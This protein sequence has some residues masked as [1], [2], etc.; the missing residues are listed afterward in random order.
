[1]I[2]LLLLL[3]PASAVQEEVDA[4]RVRGLLRRL[5]SDRVEDRTRAEDELLAMGEAVIPFLEEERKRAGAEVRRRIGAILEQVTLVPRWVKELVE[6]QNRGQALGRLQQALQKKELDGRRAVAILKASILHER[7]SDN[8]RQSLLSV[9]QRHHLDGVWPALL[10]LAVRE[11]G[12]SGNYAI[13]YLKRLRLPEEAPDAILEAIPEVRVPNHA[14]QLLQLAAGFKPD[15]AKLDAVVRT[16]VEED[17]DTSTQ[18]TLYNAFASGQ[19]RVSLGTLLELWKRPGDVRGTYAN[20]L[21]Q[22][23]LRADPDASV[24]TLKAWVGSEDLKDAL[25]AADYLGRHRVADAIVPMAEALY[26][27]LS[28]PRAGTVMRWSGIQAVGNTAESQQ[29]VGRIAHV[30]RSME[31]GKRI[32][33]W[34]EG[35]EGAPSRPAVFAVIGEL[36][37]TEHA[38]TVAR[39]LEDPDTAVR[40]E[41]VRVLGKIGGVAEVGALRARIG[42]ESRAVRREALAAVCRILGWEATPTV[43]EQLRSKDP[44]LRAAALGELPAM[45]PDAVLEALTE[46]EH[47]GK[48]WTRYAL[49]VLVVHHGEAM[50]HR[51]MARVG[52]TVSPKELEEAIRLVRSGRGGYR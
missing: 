52:D 18:Y 34:L 51:V 48:P 4:D 3:L 47:A 29:V 30:L 45:D 42:D 38:A 37:L 5:D 15:P 27:R 25:L 14:V 33:A 10:E 16:L 49:A 1:M 35:G 6:D 9:V 36:G 43:L 41:A 28:N 11:P 46:G 20:Y 8:F 50:L 2:P 26:V 13:T 24:G 32:P 22:A 21:R 23:V 31:V 40:R 44:D 17:A 12:N 19:I 39:R 7:V